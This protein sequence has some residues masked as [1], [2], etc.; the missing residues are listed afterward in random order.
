MAEIRHITSAERPERGGDCVLIEPAGSGK[1]VASCVSSHRASD[2]FY[3]QEPVDDVQAAIAAA[4]AWA[5]QNG[6]PVVYV[7]DSLAAGRTD[8]GVP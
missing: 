4:T 8:G 2:V 5:D 6:V 7:V 3:A 1:F